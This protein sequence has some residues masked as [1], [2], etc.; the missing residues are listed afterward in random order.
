ME[1]CDF[2]VVGS[3]PGG[4]VAAIRA[5]QLGYSVTLIEKEESLGGVCLNWGCIPTKS[6][7]K[8]AEVYGKLL[9][10][11][12]FGIKV[13]GSISADITKIV[14]RSRDAVG[15]LGHGVAGLMQKHGVKVCRGYAQLLGHGK[16]EVKQEKGKCSTLTA[17]HIILATG[18]RARLVPG[19]DEEMLWTAKDAMLPNAL[20]KSL[21]II[22]SGAIGVEFAS[23][24]SHMGSK[25]S[26][27]E[28]QGRILPLE[29]KTVSESMQKILQAQGIEIITGGLVQSLR[30]AG[31]TM[32]AQVKLGTQKLVTLECD[33]AIAAIGVIPNA[34]ELGLENTKATLDKSGFIVTNGLCGTD[35]PGL[36][37]IGDVAGPPCLAHKASH[38]AVIC[39]EGIAA[40]DGILKSKPHPLAL[41]NI[42]SC[43]YSIPQVAS[44]GLTEEQARA[45]GLNIKVGVS[46]ASCSGKAMVSGE[47]SGFV[48]VIL[49][50]D[51]GELLGAHMVGEEVTEM[52]NGYVIGKKL[53]A[54]DLDFLSTVFPHPTLSEMMHEA[55]LAA[56]GQPING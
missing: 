27:V 4:Y 32:Q 9:K 15:K 30:K 43:I 21:L 54:T 51:S 49:D 53:E 47:V 10:A 56:L 37:A 2:I 11:G 31:P 28:M 13:S 52:I 33:K 25:V 23:F 40:S 18:A 41:H 29:D 17:K 22:G 48:K 55:V 12:S 14:T 36:Y 3:G 46:S 6:L 50:S 5:A 19:L 20:P 35:E 38:E 26:I 34:Q 39:V 8:S 44:I 16:V 7:L 24:Y 1:S 45:Q 42:P